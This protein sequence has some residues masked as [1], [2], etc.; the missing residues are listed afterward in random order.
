MWRQVEKCNKN[1][2]EV[3][4]CISIECIT[5]LTNDEALQLL[6]QLDL[7]WNKYQEFGKYFNFL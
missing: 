3:I 1:L 4:D 5:H 7:F 6:C 2:K